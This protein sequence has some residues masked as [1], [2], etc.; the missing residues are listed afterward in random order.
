MEVGTYP[1]DSAGEAETQTRQDDQTSEDNED[2]CQMLHQRGLLAPHCPSGAVHAG[3]G[4][5]TLCR[6]SQ[7]SGQRAPHRV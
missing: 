2:L 3:H 7:H 1:G 5:P 6:Q 4:V